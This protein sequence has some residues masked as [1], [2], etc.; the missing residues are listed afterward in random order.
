M[1]NKRYNELMRALKPN[2]S[3]PNENVAVLSQEEF[4]EGWHYCTDWDYLLVGPEM[5]EYDSCT[6]LSRVKTVTQKFQNNLTN[7]S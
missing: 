6:C 7:N 2:Q 3:N 5:K 4:N 1:T